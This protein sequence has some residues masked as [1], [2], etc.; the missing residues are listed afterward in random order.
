MKMEYMQTQ[1][2]ALGGRQ[3]A[4]NGFGHMMEDEETE[5]T[6]MAKVVN[7]EELTK[8]LSDIIAL[9]QQLVEAEAKVRAER[10]NAR[11]AQRKLDHVEK[12]ASQRIVERMP[13]SNFDEDSDH[14]AMLLATVL[15]KD[16]FEYNSTTDTVE[17]K[18]GKKFLRRIE[19]NSGDVPDKQVKI[20]L[21]RNKV[22]EKMK[23]TLRRERTLSES[24]SEYSI[25]S[26]SSS[27]T[28]QRSVG[29]EDDSESVSKVSRPSKMVQQSRIPAPL[30][31][32]Q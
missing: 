30:S 1:F 21:V 29:E 24:G 26:R 25:S 10:S 14:L 23:R 18:S 13:G 7:I 32:A 22:L 16:D 12:V 20:T 11:T 6:N 8:Q 19:E 27:R 15:E 28:R 4:D 5:V 3:E 2:P 31:T 17:P 9:Q